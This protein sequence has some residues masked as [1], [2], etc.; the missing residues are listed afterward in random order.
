MDELDGDEVFA[1]FASAF[2]ALVTLAGFYGELLSVTGLARTRA[3]RLAIALAPPLGLLLLQL[4]LRCCSAHEVRAA[5][6]YDVLFLL[7]GAAWMG[8]AVR[9]MPLAGLSVWEDVVE[10]K[11]S[12][13]TVAAFGALL[14]IMLCYAGSNIGEGATIWTTF[15]P[16]LLSALA[17]LCLWVLHALLSSCWE[18][19][20]IDRDTA[21]GIRLAGL[22]VACGLIL[23]RASAGDWHSVEATVHDLV[24]QGSPA[25]LLAAVATIVHLVFRPTPKRHVGSVRVAVQTATAYIVSAALY[26]LWLGPLRHASGGE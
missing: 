17:L 20:T 9:L 6:V 11:N 8:I 23:G 12:G 18:S 2:L 5:A 7:G 24:M 19:I 22:L 1:L 4:L 10:A 26:V 13:A 14:G 21:S 3:Q 25:V 15:L 16:A